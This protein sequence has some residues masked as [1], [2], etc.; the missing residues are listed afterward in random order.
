MVRLGAALGHRADAA[1]QARPRKRDTTEPMNDPVHCVI[2]KSPKRDL[3][4]LFVPEEDEFSDV[5][6]EVLKYF[7]EPQKVMAL[8]L[9]PDKALAQSDPAEVIANLAEKGF[10]IQ[11]PPKDPDTI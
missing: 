5:P 7:G 11:M 1:A 4:Y 8:E 9:T 3:M 10:H 2:Y 6:Q